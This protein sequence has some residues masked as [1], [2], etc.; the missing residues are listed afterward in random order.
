MDEG[1]NIIRKECI[2][3]QWQAPSSGWCCLNTDNAAKSGSHIVGCAMAHIMCRSYLNLTQ[4][5]KV[6]ELG[7]STVHS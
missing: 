1:R 6:I 2:N 3:V 5:F 4:N 7:I